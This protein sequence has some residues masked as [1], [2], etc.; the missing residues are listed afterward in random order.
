ML[1]LEVCDGGRI[2]TTFADEVRF[3]PTLGPLELLSRDAGPA[4]ELLLLCCCWCCCWWSDEPPP[5]APSGSIEEDPF[6]STMLSMASCFSCQSP[7]PPRELPASFARVVAI[8]VVVRSACP[9]EVAAVGGQAC[10]S[11][12]KSLPSYRRLKEKRTL[13]V[14]QP[15]MARVVS[16]SIHSLTQSNGSWQPW[17]RWSCRKVH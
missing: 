16:L 9:E 14:K 15:L 12:K 2:C 7:P 4:P 13:P 10:H 1:P 6:S 8:L 5:E 17:T 11:Q 3:S